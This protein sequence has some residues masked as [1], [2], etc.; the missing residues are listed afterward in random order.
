MLNNSPPKK[1]LSPPS[2]SLYLGHNRNP[3]VINTH[4]P[5]FKCQRFLICPKKNTKSEKR[6]TFLFTPHAKHPTP[7][8][9]ESQNE[10]GVFRLK[11]TESYSPF[12][13]ISQQPKKMTHTT[14]KPR[15]MA[16]GVMFLYWLASY[17]LK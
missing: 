4:P 1:P 6:H 2:S 3:R 16:H 10:Q 17:N 7:L 9:S 5:S 15:K 13:T 14:M 11:E 12:I 8:K